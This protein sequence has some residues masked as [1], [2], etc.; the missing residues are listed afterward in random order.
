MIE[1]FD[2]LFFDGMPV[3]GAQGIIVVE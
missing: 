1:D 3:D 2:E